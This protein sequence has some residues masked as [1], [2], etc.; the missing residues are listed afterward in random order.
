MKVFLEKDTVVATLRLSEGDITL[1]GI[2]IQTFAD[3]A[4]FIGIEY[5]NPTQ[6]LPSA[7]SA[8]SAVDKKDIE[9]TS[10]IPR[11]K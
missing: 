8:S 9:L 3:Q 5:S 10:V 6:D 7:H 11:V 2:N 4:S 1:L